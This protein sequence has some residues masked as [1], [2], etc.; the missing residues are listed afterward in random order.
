MTDEE[1]RELIIKDFE[2]L[3]LEC[4]ERIEA[5]YRERPEIAAAVDRWAEEHDEEMKADLERRIAEIE[6]SWMNE[7]RG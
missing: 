1:L 6:R 2:R 3:A 7:P 5:I 4:E